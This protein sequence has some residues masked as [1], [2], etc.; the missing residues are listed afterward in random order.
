MARRRFDSTV[1]RPGPDADL[2]DWGMYFASVALEIEHRTH[3][4]AHPMWRDIAAV[5]GVV[6]FGI[7][8]GLLAW[9]VCRSFGGP[10]R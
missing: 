6:G 7:S 5:L 2:K 9:H 10:C 3:R 8:V 1:P 4:H